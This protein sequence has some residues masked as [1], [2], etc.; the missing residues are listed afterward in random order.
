MNND[1]SRQL[2]MDFAQPVRTNRFKTA[3][4]EGRFVLAVEAPTPEAGSSEPAPSPEQLAALLSSV[5][6]NLSSETVGD[7]TRTLLEGYFAYAA[8]DPATD[9]AKL[10]EAALSYLRSDKARKI[11]SDGISAA[12]TENSE[13][14][15]SAEDLAGAM[16][17]IFEDFPLYVEE[18]PIGEDVDF[19]AYF[20]GYLKSEVAPAQNGCN[21][22]GITLRFNPNI[23]AR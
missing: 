3:L 23:Y 15:V 2:N 12:I 8:S 17:E 16:R 1:R 19:S 22:S 14:L 6:I 5:R 7:L 4:D 20:D 9:L 21:R 18:H 11:L 13:G 10:P